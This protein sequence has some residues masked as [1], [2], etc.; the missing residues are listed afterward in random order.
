MSLQGRPNPNLA[1]LSS[2][3]LSLTSN[4]KYH[5]MADFLF[6]LFGY[7]KLSADLLVWLYKIISRF[8][9]LAESKPVK[10]G[11]SYT[12]MLSILKSVTGLNATK[13]LIFK[14]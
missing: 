14:S 1:N 11:V 12:A 10:Q 9:C 13:T 2:R 6:Y 4:G 5:C 8:T 3:E 7:V